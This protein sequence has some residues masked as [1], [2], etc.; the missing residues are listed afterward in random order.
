MDNTLNAYPEHKGFSGTI[1]DL[2]Q[3]FTNFTQEYLKWKQPVG[4]W[5][6]AR[7][8]RYARKEYGNFLEPYV[9]GAGLTIEL[10][11]KPGAQHDL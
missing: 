10:V 7:V 4:K 3:L 2:D 5:R 11:D 8:L 1:A 6:E 9:Q